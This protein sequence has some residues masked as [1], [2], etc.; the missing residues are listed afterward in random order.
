MVLL[1]RGYYKNHGRKSPSMCFFKNPC[2][3]IL[4]SSFLAGP[5]WSPLFS[6]QME[7]G[8]VEWEG[9]R[10]DWT[11]SS[12]E[13]GSCFTLVVVKGCYD[14]LVIVI[15][16]YCRRGCAER[17]DGPSVCPNWEKLVFLLVIWSLLVSD[18]E[19]LRSVVV[20]PLGGS[21]GKTWFHH[22]LAYLSGFSL[23]RVASHSRM[24]S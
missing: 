4:T 8:K 22:H 9:R 11:L 7:E 2:F 18:L 6:S 23:Q 5:P 20:L 12:R 3:K 19:S 21:G 1:N 15:G 14:V 16:W 13:S 17:I 10:G 24:A